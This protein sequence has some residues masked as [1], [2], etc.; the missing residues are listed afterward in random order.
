MKKN[1]NVYIENIPVD[2]QLDDKEDDDDNG[3]DNNVGL[4]LIDSGHRRGFSATSISNVLGQ[5]ATC[6]SINVG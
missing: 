1:E 4:I 5:T 3:D 6:G 2:E